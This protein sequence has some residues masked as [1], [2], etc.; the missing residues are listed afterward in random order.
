MAGQQAAACPRHRAGSTGQGTGRSLSPLNTAQGRRQLARPPLPLRA[1]STA[2]T[3]EEGKLLQ[4]MIRNISAFA[5]P[6]LCRP[7]RALPPACGP[8]PA[9]PLP[10][11]PLAP[12]SLRSPI[13]GELLEK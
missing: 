10:P 3:G 11:E 12:A 6:G 2:T 4:G 9:A 1:A 8:G 5:A 7:T 13:L